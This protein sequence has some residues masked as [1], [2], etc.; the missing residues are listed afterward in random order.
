[1]PSLRFPPSSFLLRRNGGSGGTAEDTRRLRSG[2]L[3]KWQ[4]ATFI[5]LPFV[6]H[7]K[8]ALLFVSYFLLRTCRKSLGAQRQRHCQRHRFFVKALVPVLA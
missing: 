3:K 2:A 7:E 4:A 8:Y 5:M 6:F 1:M